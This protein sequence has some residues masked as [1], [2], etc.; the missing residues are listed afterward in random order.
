MQQSRRVAKTNY[1]AGLG[2]IPGASDAGAMQSWILWNMIGLYPI[3]GQTTFLIGSPWF[4]QMVI[5]TPSGK[6]LTI[7]STGGNSDTA[8]YVQSL[9]VNG[10]P[11]TQ[12]WLTWN[13]IFDNGGAMDFVLGPNPTNWDTGALPPSPATGKQGAMDTGTPLKSNT[14]NQTVPASPKLIPFRKPLHKDTR[15]R[16]AIVVVSVVGFFAIVSGVL[17]FL[18]FKKIGV[19]GRKRAQPD[20]ESTSNDVETKPAAQLEGSGDKPEVIEVHSDAMT[21]EEDPKIAEINDKRTPVTIAE[22]H[23][24]TRK[25]MNFWKKKK[26]DSA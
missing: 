18:W 25:K 1:N 9:Q 4:D 19:F 2:G 6:P 23:N 26:E 22:V 24:E 5:Q 21:R 12:N 11:W 16:T 14:N 13:D 20:T 7:T 8:F 10:K 3:T 15:V 17:A